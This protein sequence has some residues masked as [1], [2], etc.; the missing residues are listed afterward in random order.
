MKKTRLAWSAAI[1]L[2]MPLSGVSAAQTPAEIAQ[3][4]YEEVLYLTPNVENG[5]NVYLVCS[6]CHRP[7]GWGTPNGSYPQI[8]GQHSTVI[9]KQLADI[10]ARNRE[11]PLMYPFAIPEMLGGP[12]Q[13]ADV[14]AYVAQ[15]PMAPHNGVGPGDDLELGKRLYAQDC[16]DC[17]GD[18]GEGNQED[19]IPALAGQ[20][21]HY[22]MR[23]FDLIREGRRKNS[24]PKMV[25]KIQGFTARE[26]AAVVDYTSRLRPPA[27]RVAEAGWTNPDFPGFVR[28]RAPEPLP[29]PSATPVMPGFE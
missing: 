15:L 7:E 21:Y 2:L 13:I 4:E 1:T 24:D 23:Q 26:Q 25:K 14:A 8:A 12:Q 11:N 22:L 17:H 19:H 6:V 20:H 5:R 29:R 3:A 9:I 27:E 28:E 16:A 10:R 18:R